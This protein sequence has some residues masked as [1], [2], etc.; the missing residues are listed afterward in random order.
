[1]VSLTA[2]LQAMSEELVEAQG[3]LRA[4]VAGAASV[5]RLSQVAAAARGGSMDG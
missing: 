5:P 3:A 1:M 4:E 2:L